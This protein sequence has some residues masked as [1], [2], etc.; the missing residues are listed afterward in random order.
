MKLTVRWLW[1]GGVVAVSACGGPGDLSAPKPPAQGGAV[2]PARERVVDTGR[3]LYL[4]TCASCH[5]EDARGSIPIE[6]RR[7][8][9]EEELVGLIRDGVPGVHEWRYEEEEGRDLARYVLSLM[10]GR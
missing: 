4:A 5:G 1:V 3:E 7:F 6:G 2:L 9:T 10:K 8:R